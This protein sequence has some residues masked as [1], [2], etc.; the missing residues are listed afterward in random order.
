MPMGP[1]FTACLSDYLTYRTAEEKRKAKHKRKNEDNLSTSEKARKSL[2][3]TSEKARKK[4]KKTEPIKSPSE[5]LSHTSDDDF[6][7]AS[8]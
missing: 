3:S 4:K 2:S 8:S 6:D 7:S 5:S 1:A